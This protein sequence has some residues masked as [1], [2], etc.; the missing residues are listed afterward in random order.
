MNRNEELSQPPTVDDRT[1]SQLQ[2]ELTALAD[3]YVTDWNSET[4]DMADQLLKVGGEFGSEVLQRLNRLPEKHR[5]GFLQ[6]LG[7]GPQP[8]Q[9]ARLP[10]SV[11]PAGDVGRNVRVPGG[12]QMT[13]STRDDETTVFEIPPDS[14]FEATPASLVDVYAVDPSEDRLTSHH[15]L[16]DGDGEQL[17]VGENHQQHALYLGDES[18]FELDSGGVLEIEASGHI[19]DGFEQAIVWEYYGTTTP[20]GTG[21]TDGE[22]G[23]SE[24]E[25][26]HRL[27]TVDT[28]EESLRSRVDRLPK[29]AGNDESGYTTRRQLTGEFVETSIEGI[30][31][32]WLRC[33]LAE[34]T[35]ACFRTEIETLSV[36]TN[37]PPDCE[38]S[39]PDGAFVND[40]PLAVD[41]NEDIEPLGQFP[42]PASTLYLASDETLTKPGAQARV[43]FEPPETPHEPADNSPA[44]DSPAADFGALDE[45]P[46][47]SWE[48]WNG[49]GWAGLEVDDGTEHLQQAGEIRFIV[50]E[51]G[52]STL[53]IEVFR[54]PVD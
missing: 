5:A 54:F 47:L 40:V 23:E 20:S 21:Q 27:P 22:S 10:V 1:P 14:G 16:A 30:E 6:T 32:R 53:V 28:A 36:T 52:E 33:R 4:T 34:P 43:S 39:T 2:A 9:A 17:F 37:S 50:P 51:D 25:G 41:G 35:A 49:S 11:E 46:K 29:R 8:P 31:S 24:I 45:P 12:T 18:L 38:Q 48:Y 19:A 7:K 42:Q 26:W 13:A 3:Q 44:D 15:S